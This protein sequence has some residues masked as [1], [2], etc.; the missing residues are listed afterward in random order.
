[1]FDKTKKKLIHFHTSGNIAEDFVASKKKKSRRL[2]AVIRLCFF[3]HLIGGAVCAAA[4]YIFDRDSFVT[5]VLCAVIETVIAFFAAGGEMT[6]KASLVGIDL[7]LAA[8]GTIKAVSS[9]GNERILYFVFGGAAILGAIL[10]VAE[11]IAAHLRDYLLD[12]P[13]EKL[14]TE[15][16]T[17]IEEKGAELSPISPS[18]LIGRIEGVEKKPL[19]VAPKLSEMRKIAIK[20]NNILNGAPKTGEYT[21]FSKTE[22]DIDDD[23]NFE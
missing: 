12:F 8:A 18:E 15:D 7:I 3:G 20:L 17:P 14:K 11:M 19:N 6:T 10:A 4:C 13:A 23:D 16:V 9:A 22:I 5:L 21:T 1:M 2:A